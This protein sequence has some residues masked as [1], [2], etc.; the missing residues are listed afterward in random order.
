MMKRCFV[1]LVAVAMILLGCGSARATE[2][3]TEAE[4]EEQY[5]IC[6][7]TLQLYLNGDDANDLERLFE[8]LTVEIPNYKMSSNLAYYTKV[9][10]FIETGNYAPVQ[11][12]L[13]LMGVDPTF[14]TWLE[15][16]EGLG[17]L[18]QVSFYGK[19]RQAE[20]EGRYVEA[21]DYYSRCGTF[22]DANTRSIELLLSDEFALDIKY[23]EALLL[24][25]QRRYRE[26]MELMREVAAFNYGDSVAYVRLMEEILATPTPTPVPTP[27]PTPTPPPQLTS[28]V[29]RGYDTQYKHGAKGQERVP[30]EVWN[31]VDDNINTNYNWLIYTSGYQ[32]NTPELTFFFNGEPLTEFR[33]RNGNLT[34]SNAYQQYARIKTMQ[35]RVYNS[36]GE[37][38]HLQTVVPEDR[39]MEDY[40]CFPLDRICYDVARVELWYREG[41]KGKVHT[42]YCYIT[43]VSFIGYD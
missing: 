17:T 3:L 34:S 37:L 24:Y 2:Y 28:V 36:H 15:E 33:I 13:D 23:Q 30:D 14:N 25:Q 6:I 7:N 31:L 9:L 21:V 29:P 20:A 26:A 39:Y 5:N 22:Y 8:K 41:I 19:G 40:Q 35:L 38:I 1:L 11:A 16:T 4:R 43:D 18:E 12:V 27:T 10:I 42:N 32:D